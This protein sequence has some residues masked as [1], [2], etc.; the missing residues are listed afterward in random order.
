MPTT[1]NQEILA[2]NSPRNSNETVNNVERNVTN[3]VT[4]GKRCK[5]K[6]ASQQL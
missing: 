2:E 5:Q 6:Q 4:I 1:T 3:P